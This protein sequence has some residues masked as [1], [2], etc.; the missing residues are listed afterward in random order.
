MTIGPDPMTSTLLM[1]SR[2][3]IQAPLPFF[4]CISFT[5]RSNR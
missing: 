2:F 1:S 5:N 4:S 3:G